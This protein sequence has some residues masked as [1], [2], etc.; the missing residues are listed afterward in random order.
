M[1]AAP[2]RKPLLRS[3][4][5]ALALVVAAG[6]LVAVVIGL[7]EPRA[8]ARTDASLAAAQADAP[9]SAASPASGQ[10]APRVLRGGGAWGSARKAP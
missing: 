9:V 1:I 3:L 7:I 5:P 10:S 4:L 8:A 6:A 2:S